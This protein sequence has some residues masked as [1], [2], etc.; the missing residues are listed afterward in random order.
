MGFSR[1]MTKHDR[2]CV[3]QAMEITG[4]SQWRD[5]SMKTLSGGQR[6]RVYLAM[7]VAQE[8]PLLL[9]DEP[10]TFLDIHYRLSI[11]ELAKQ[12]NQAGKTMIMT[13]HDLSD[14]LTVAHRVCLM[15]RRGT[16]C[17][18]G[19]PEQVFQSGQLDRIFSVRSEQVQLRSGNTAYVFTSG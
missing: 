7:T 15:D 3:E 13:L 12:L 2:D 4:V 14:A 16:I 1:Q 19:T 6:Q 5:R 8:T 11:M 18:T 17:V 10:T 9:W